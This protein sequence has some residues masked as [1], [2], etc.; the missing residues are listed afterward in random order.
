MNQKMPLFI[1]PTKEILWGKLGRKNYLKQKMKAHL[2]KMVGITNTVLFALKKL[3]GVD[4]HMVMLIIV[5]SGFARS[6]LL[7]WSKQEVFHILRMKLY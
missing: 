3:V 7:N 2:L 5:I 4:N 1:K 6:V